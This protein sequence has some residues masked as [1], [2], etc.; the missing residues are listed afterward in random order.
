MLKFGTF[1]VR[2]IAPSCE[3]CKQTKNEK[4][5]VLLSFWFP[6]ILNVIG[7]QLFVYGPGF[8]SE[9][10]MNEDY[11][12]GPNPGQVDNLSRRRIHQSRT[13]IGSQ[14]SKV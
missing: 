1:C 3:K 12:R 2:D 14:G 13:I 7:F 9:T 5:K 6:A 8:Q 10:V 4:Y 11:L